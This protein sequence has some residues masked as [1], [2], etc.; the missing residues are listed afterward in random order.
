MDADSETIGVDLLG[1]LDVDVA[2]S[3]RRRGVE[4]RV[5]RRQLST[6]GYVIICYYKGVSNSKKN[7][8]TIHA[9]CDLTGLLVAP[10]DGCKVSLVVHEATVEEWLHIWVRRR[11]VDLA[12]A[13]GVL[14]VREPIIQSVVSVDY[15]WPRS[16]QKN[17]HGHVVAR[18]QESVVCVGTSNDG[19]KH[20]GLV[21]LVLEVTVPELIKLR[22]HLLHLLLGRANLEERHTS[23]VK[24]KNP[25]AKLA[26]P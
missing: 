1:S 24:S 5:V 9:T 17:L 20:D 21:G 6:E 8:H 4:M 13:S 10:S 7:E 2:A 26:L 25:H 23:L 3:S 12:T 18:R 11:D 14:E 16:H 15:M 22:S 19:A